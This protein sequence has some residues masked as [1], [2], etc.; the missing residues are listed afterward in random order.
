MFRRFAGDYGSQNY[1]TESSSCFT[2][3]LMAW[4]LTSGYAMRTDLGKTNLFHRLGRQQLLL[5]VPHDRFHGERQEAGYEDPHHRPPHYPHHPA[6][7]R[8]APASPS[9]NRWCPGSCHRHVLIE[10][11]WIDRAYI[12]RYVHGFEEY[13][14]YVREFI[15]EKGEELTGVP[16]EQIRAGCCHDHE[17]GSFCI[18]ESSAPIG[19]HLNGLQNYRAMMALLVITGNVDRAGGQL[20]G[21]HTYMERYCGFETREEHFMEERLSP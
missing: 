13:A 12:D 10:N 21:P 8:P 5:P 19:H 3:G 1:G 15:P 17:A 14:A 6:S 18:N 4:Q 20:P 16:A 11:D 7:G 9:G 2:S